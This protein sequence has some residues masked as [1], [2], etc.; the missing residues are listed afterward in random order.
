MIEAIVVITF[1]MLMLLFVTTMALDWYE[2]NMEYKAILEYCLV[3]QK[4]S[5]YQQIDSEKIKEDL[6]N[7]K[8]E[9]SSEIKNKLELLKVENIS[10]E[11]VEKLFNFY[12]ENYRDGLPMFENI[13]NFVRIANQSYF[14]YEILKQKVE[15]Q[16]SENLKSFYNECNYAVER[17]RYE[18]ITDFEKLENSKKFVTF[19][20]AKI[21]V[22]KIKENKEFLTA[23]EAL[24]LEEENR[25]LAELEEIKKEETKVQIEE[26]EKSMKAIWG[27]FISFIKW[28]AILIVAFIS[29]IITFVTIKIIF[30]NRK[31][32]KIEKEKMKQKEIEDN[33]LV[34]RFK[35]LK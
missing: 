18:G 25:K 34:N 32:V 24:K 14:D 22:D 15:N 20:E 28:V 7:R 30:K 4:I 1:C 3:E 29:L 23:E 21:V 31:E 10:N 12:L 6:S 5:D 16:I 17:F 26:F 13:W 8:W 2:S 19:E 35:K 33:K 9:I 27:W 11:F